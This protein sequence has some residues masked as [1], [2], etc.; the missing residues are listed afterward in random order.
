V[1]YD[2]RV[3]YEARFRRELGGWDMALQIAARHVENCASRVTETL[4]AV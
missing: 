3:R 4:L 1:R 2:A